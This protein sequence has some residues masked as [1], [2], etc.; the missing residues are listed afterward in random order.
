MEI[1]SQEILNLQENQNL[2][3]FGPDKKKSQI[4]ASEEPDKR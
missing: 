3:N 4:E 2:N 1:Q